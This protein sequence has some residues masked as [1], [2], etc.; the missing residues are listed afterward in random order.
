M[1]AG[2]LSRSELEAAYRVTGFFSVS[3]AV[4]TLVSNLLPSRPKNL[5]SEFKDV[6]ACPPVRKTRQIRRMIAYEPASE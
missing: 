6:L 3:D 4:S 2:C 5:Q 1:R